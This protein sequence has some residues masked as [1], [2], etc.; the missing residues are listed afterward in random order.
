MCGVGNPHCEKF[1]DVTAEGIYGT[2]N[3]KERV[4]LVGA[5]G[6]PVQVPAIQMAKFTT[7]TVPESSLPSVTGDGEVAR[8]R[9][10]L[11][12]VVILVRYR[13]RVEVSEPDHDLVQVGTASGAGGEQIVGNI[14]HDLPGDTLR[15]LPGRLQHQPQWEDT[16]DDVPHGTHLHGGNRT[17]LLVE[18]SVELNIGE[19]LDASFICPSPLC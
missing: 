2:A 18:P 1:V 6:A 4:N 8:D 5:V 19:A 9:D 14:S 10:C 16:R 13:P 7:R 3:G 15:P 11:A 12:V 17:E